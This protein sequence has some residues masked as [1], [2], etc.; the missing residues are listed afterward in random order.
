MLDVVELLEI[1][2]I[3]RERLEEILVKLNRTEKLDDF[4]AL[5]GMG[6][7]AAKDEPINTYGVGKILVVGKCEVKEEKLAAVAKKL[8]IDKN[9]IEF[10]LNYEDGKTFDFRKTQWSD[11]YSVILVG[12]MPHSGKSKGEYDSI[13]SAIEQQDGYPPVVRVGTN[14]LKITRTSFKNTLENLIQERRIA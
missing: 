1:E 10:H 5:I 9:R 13:I 12:Q 6:D 4:L 7:L 11:N 2:E 14:G 8:G 3:V